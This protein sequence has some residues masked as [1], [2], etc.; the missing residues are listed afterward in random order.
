MTKNLEAGVLCAAEPPIT[1]FGAGYPAAALVG[2]IVE[3]KGFT[4]E[5]YV[6]KYRA[7]YPDAKSSSSS[8]KE[9]FF[10]VA[11]DSFPG[12]YIRVSSV[13][14]SFSLLGSAQCTLIRTLVVSVDVDDPLEQMDSLTMSLHKK[15]AINMLGVE[16]QPVTL[17][18][19]DRPLFTY[20][21]AFKEKNDQKKNSER[22]RQMSL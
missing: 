5:E 16:S 7:E 4:M 3:T 13:I 11:L 14:K 22:Q 8:G 2:V 20:F 10:K 19:V 9:R 21:A 6:A 1:G 12:V 18:I 17:E 15:I